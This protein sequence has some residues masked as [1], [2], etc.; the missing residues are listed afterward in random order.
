MEIK[1][2][3]QMNENIWDDIKYGASKLGRYKVDG[4]ILGKDKTTK[5]SN[6]EIEDLLKKESNKLL[7]SLMSVVKEKSPEFPNDRKKITFL[8]GVLTI[9]AFYDSIVAATSKNEGEEGYLPIEAAN[10]I[11]DDLRKVVKKSLDIDLAAVYTTFENVNFDE[12]SEDELY[13]LSEENIFKKAVSGIGKGISAVKG[14]KD[15]AFDKMFGAKSGKDKENRTGSRQ[16]AKLQNTSGNKDFET[17][18]FSKKGLE[19]NRLPLLLT[20]VGV[21]LG[22]LSW[23]ASTDWFKG[24]FTKIVD[25]P[26]VENVPNVVEESSASIHEIQK[27]EGVY[28]LLGRLTDYKIDATSSPQ[29][30]T[31]TLSKIGGGDAKK[32]IDLLC[33]QGGVMMKPNE[34]KAAFDEFISNPD[35]Y[36]NMGE[37]FKGTADG[38]GKVGH[39]IFGT[40]SGR[41]ITTMLTQSVVKVIP[42]IVAKKVAITGAGY[43]TAKGL[44]A[45]L[46][47]IGVALIAAGITVKVLREKGQRQSRAKTLNDLLQS[48]Q[49]IK[50]DKANNLRG[51]EMDKKSDKNDSIISVP[52]D[53]TIYPLMIK[54]LKSLNSLLISS[55]GV[56]LNGENNKDVDKWSDRKERESK[57][58][59]DKRVY[60]N[61]KSD[62][63]DI[64]K[65]LVKESLLEKKMDKSPR[66]VNI[67]DNETYLKQAVQNVRK[68]LKS[69]T[70]ESDKGIGIDTAFIE[71]ILSKKMESSTKQPLLDMYSEVYEYL[72]GTKSSTLGEFDKLY[73]ESVDIISN[74]AKR[75]VVAEKFARFSKRTMQFEGQ[76]FYQSLGEFGI[77]LEEFNETLKQIMNYFKNKNKKVE[78][79]NIIRYNDFFKS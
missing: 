27:G 71:S 48:L 56:L 9:A 59:L 52:T 22:A 79:N 2:F 65:P 4:K 62:G 51:D 64:K 66:N 69:L 72:Y 13:L 5:K 18:R 39:E 20:S 55:Q 36:K 15:K 8:R 57:R 10:E 6:I 76:G 54:N 46:G 70:N 30:F 41:Q 43:A 61:T 40:L 50:V 23:I 28:K 42:T 21:S 78:S 45:I 32:G 58:D 67:D 11:I 75:Q 34:A 63:K 26:T 44:G 24:L 7:K 31:E 38:T 35:K 53:K 73:K 77:D 17:S 33:Q 25:N 47:P 29:E 74:K 68:S 3:N 49:S 16:S 12:I 60:R 19:S 14:V 1:K 37:F